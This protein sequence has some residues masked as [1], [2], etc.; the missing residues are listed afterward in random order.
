[1]FESEVLEMDDKLDTENWSYLLVDGEVTCSIQDDDEDRPSSEHSR[2][3]FHEQEIKLSHGILVSHVL[4]ENAKYL[5][6]HHL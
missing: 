5:T 2:R 3:I 1:M 6:L 4:K